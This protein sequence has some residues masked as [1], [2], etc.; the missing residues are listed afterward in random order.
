MLNFIEAVFLKTYL[1]QNA[2]IK[3]S[4]SNHQKILNPHSTKVNGYTSQD[5]D[6]ISDSFFISRKNFKNF[7]IILRNHSKS[8]WSNF[9]SF[10]FPIRWQKVVFALRVATPQRPTNIKFF[11]LL[12]LQLYQQFNQY[13]SEK[14]SY[15]MEISRKHTS[16]TCPVSRFSQQ[17]C[18][19][20]SL[21]C[22]MKTSP[23]VLS[24][25]TFLFSGVEPGCSIERP[26]YN[27]L[28]K[29]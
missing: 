13:T 5:A 12:Q 1:K 18:I 22:F 29:R 28:L 15:S 24:A 20:W 7:Y 14:P 16:G 26:A 8:K 2:N 6:L 19:S 10:F 3:F 27:K 21:D 9:F 23:L 11:F 4:T 17:K 25:T